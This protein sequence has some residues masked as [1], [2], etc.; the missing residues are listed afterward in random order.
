MKA[1]LT[2]AAVLAFAGFNQAATTFQVPLAFTNNADKSLTMTI[3]PQSVT[4]P[5][6]IMAFAPMGLNMLGGFLRNGDS[7]APFSL[8]IQVAVNDDG[9]LSAG[10]MG[11]MMLVPADIVNQFREVLAYVQTL[12]STPVQYSG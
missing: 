9:S 12:I 3:G 11:F 8:P 5:A 1:V 2:L 10:A 6:S 4:L 7:G